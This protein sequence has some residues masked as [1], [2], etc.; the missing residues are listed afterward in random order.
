M[1]TRC[2]R[3]YANR[4]FMDD[5]FIHNAG[6]SSEMPKAVEKPASFPNLDALDHRLIE[7][8]GFHEV[9]VKLPPVLHW[10]LAPVACLEIILDKKFGR[11]AQIN[12]PGS[13]SSLHPGGDLTVSPQIS[14]ANFF[15]PTTPATTGQVSESSRASKRG[16]PAAEHRRSISTKKPACQVLP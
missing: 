16:I 14:Y 5:N 13:P 2:R 3:K 6:S 9:H 8:L 11:A 12:R 15:C 7:L 1:N 10:Q 4:L